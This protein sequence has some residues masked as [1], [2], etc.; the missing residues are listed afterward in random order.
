MH[1]T[2][3]ALRLHDLGLAM[4][5]KPRKTIYSLTG[6]LLM[7]IG[8]LMVIVSTIFWYFLIKYQE[9]E[10]LTNFVKY[11][12]S[13]VDNVKKSTRYGMLTFQE[14]LIQQTVE[15]VG[16]TEGVI[17]IRIFNCRGRVAH[18]SRKEDIGTFVDKRSP[19]C[20]TCHTS[21]KPALMPKWTIHK[22]EEGYRVLNIV[23]PI[24]NEPSCY[25]SSCHVHPKEK[26]ILGLV[27][28]NLSLALLDKA[29]NQQSIAIT[30]Y[31]FIFL[32]VISIVLCSI[33]WKLVSTPVSIL[34]EG[35]RK[36]AAGNLDHKVEISS[37]DEMGE[38]AKSFNS[39]TE[40][41]SKA[42]MELL[43]WGQ[44]LEKK[45]E[46]KT[47]AIKNAQEQLI[48]SEKLASL[49]RMAAGVAHEI[50]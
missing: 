1:T 45:V 36:V 37:S 25:T 3:E 13:F 40:D 49:G 21:G 15:A 20:F 2:A 44:T 30:M 47:E 48:H 18:S 6:R 28:A 24:Y 31:V 12:M 27:E 32:S 46:E 7:A 38:L 43:E 42:K 10:L 16:S 4:K 50:N 19:V 22:S 23:Q 8:A 9:K 5:I 11:G 35:M 41:L 14:L 26:A 39:M 17:Q 29:V 34:A 33:L